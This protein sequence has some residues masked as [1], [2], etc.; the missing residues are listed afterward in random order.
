MSLRHFV[1]VCLFLFSILTSYHTVSVYHVIF[2]FI[3]QL[4]HS[5]EADYTQVYNLNLRAIHL[6]SIQH[7]DKVSD[8]NL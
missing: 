1:P 4:K 2:L 6:Q 8:D 3:A 5:G 7:L